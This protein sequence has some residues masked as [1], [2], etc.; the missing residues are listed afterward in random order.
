ML[1]PKSNVIK[2]YHRLN[3][4]TKVNDEVPLP[5]AMEYGI[6]LMFFFFNFPY[7]MMF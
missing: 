5:L 3:D 6:L 1:Y 2:G 7:F 4:G